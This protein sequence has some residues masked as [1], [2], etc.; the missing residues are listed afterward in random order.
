MIRSR[1]GDD[2]G[3]VTAFVVVFTMALVFVAGLVVD[4]GVLLTTKRQAMNIAEQAARAGAQGLSID[5]LR[6]TGVQALDP[7]SAADTAHRYLAAA[8]YRGDVAVAGNRVTVSVAIRRRP[9]I[10]G[11]GGLGA[12]TVTGHA[13]ARNARGVVEADT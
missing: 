1:R 13:V 11:L 8:G 6:S 12:V 5:Q 4:G 3:Q 10:L 2:C 7:Q 9:L